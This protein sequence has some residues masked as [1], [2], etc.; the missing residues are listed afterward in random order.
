MSKKIFEVRRFI[1]RDEIEKHGCKY[2]F[3][4]ERTK[5]PPK[6]FR[7][8]MDMDKLNEEIDHKKNERYGYC[9]HSACPYADIFEN[10]KNY[11]EF[12]KDTDTMAAAI[13][14]IFANASSDTYSL[15]VYQ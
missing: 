15:G 10:Y 8:F 6:D 11:E 3:D 4:K 1:T 12:F 14:G 9:P 13:R 5:K 7:S 2:C